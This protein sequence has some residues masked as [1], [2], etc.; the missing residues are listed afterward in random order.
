MALAVIAAGA[1]QA[2]PTASDILSLVEKNY[3]PIRDYT[4]DVEVSVDS[5]QM[6]MPRSTATVYYKCPDKVRL[7]P[8]EG[9]ML[10]PKNAFPGNPVSA[11]KKNFSASYTGMCEVA[12]EPTYVLKLV[13]R[14]DEAPGVMK[15]L[16]EKK[17]GVIVGMDS[18]SSET[19][20]KSRWSYARVDGKYWLP[21]QIN[22]EMSGTMPAQASKP[23][24]VSRK[25]ARSNKGTALV[26]FKNYRINKGISDSIFATQKRLKR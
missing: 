24:E 13:P 16:V 6:K 5:P 11:I 1:V 9:F 25:P 12:G 26:K 20:L 17:R 19:K 7:V 15:L 18:D 8:R 2:K 22:V 4:V 21:S 3:C 23:R 14:T 10:L